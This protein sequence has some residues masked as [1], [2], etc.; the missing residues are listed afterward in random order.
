MLKVYY[1]YVIMRCI[2]FGFASSMISTA[3][4]G[5]MFMLQMH[6]YDVLVRFP[7]ILRDL[8]NKIV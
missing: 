8:R 2:V 7:R 4:L 3:L 6:L 1:W 5:L